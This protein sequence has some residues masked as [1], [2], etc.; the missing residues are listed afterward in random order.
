VISCPASNR[1]Q[2]RCG[3]PPIRLT[4]EPALVRLSQAV[5]QAL[6]I[7]PQSGKVVDDRD[8]FEI[9]PDYARN[10]QSVRRME[11]STIDRR[12]QP[13]VLAG[14]LDIDSTGSSGL[15]IC[16]CFNIPIATFVDVPGFLP[17]PP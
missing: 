9:R 17:L 5:Q 13:M 10:I 4:V 12:H 3:R 2:R 14:C 6:R 7:G 1:A 11:G 16:D 15:S 8:F